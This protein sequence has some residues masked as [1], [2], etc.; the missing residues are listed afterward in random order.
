[1]VEV[2]RLELVA[3]SDWVAKRRKVIIKK[4]ERPLPDGGI[5]IVEIIDIGDPKYRDGIMYT[6]RCMSEDGKMLFAVENSHGKPH[7]HWRNKKEYVDLDWKAAFL[8][9]DE[10]LEEHIGKTGW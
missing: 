10:M 6:F 7:I 9:F 3:E 2:I 1:M 5:A 8:K 4:Y